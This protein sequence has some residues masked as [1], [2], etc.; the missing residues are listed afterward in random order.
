MKK[1]QPFWHFCALQKYR[2]LNKRSYNP[3]YGREPVEVEDLYDG[4]AEIDHEMVFEYR[5]GIVVARETV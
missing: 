5:R 1:T 2:I 4:P 3:F